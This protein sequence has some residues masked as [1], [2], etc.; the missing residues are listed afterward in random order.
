MPPE[1]CAKNVE[2]AVA[3]KLQEDHNLGEEAARYVAEVEAKTFVFDRSERE[4]A[5]MRAIS[6]SDLANWAAEVFLHRARRLSIHVHKG[7]VCDPA[8]EALPDGAE[9]IRNPEEF[10]AGLASWSSEECPL[11][12]VQRQGTVGASL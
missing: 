1:V 7:S 10:K 12:S 4:A 6:Q 9:L 2:S 8:K 3:N 11:P 5:V